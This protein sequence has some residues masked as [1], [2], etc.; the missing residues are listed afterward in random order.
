MNNTF[1][2]I[3]DFPKIPANCQLL[4]AYC[5]LLSTCC[6]LLIAGCL[7]LT[8]CCPLSTVC[9]I[10]GWRSVPL[11]R[12]VPSIR[13]DNLSGLLRDRISRS[14]FTLRLSKRLTYD[15]PWVIPVLAGCIEGTAWHKKKCMAYLYIFVCSDQ[16][17]F[18]G[19]LV[20]AQWP[21]VDYWMPFVGSSNA[22]GGSTE[23][24]S[25]KY[26]S[27]S[28]VRPMPLRETAMGIAGT[29]ESLCV[30]R[31]M[32]FNGLKTGVKYILL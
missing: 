3:K 30:V 15:G 16:S 29:D 4:S 1:C 6:S 13:P 7:L 8:A 22:F 19:G 28:L 10:P 9:R 20:G 32:T 21:C 14:S 26:R 17:L 18:T 5:L 11:D 23:C 24:L 27:P 31:W 2:R 25:A 12:S